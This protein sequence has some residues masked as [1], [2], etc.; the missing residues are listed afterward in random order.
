[1]PLDDAIVAYTA[2][3]NRDAALVM[4]LFAADGIEAYLFDNDS[5]AGDWIG[6]MVQAFDKPQVWISR[7]DAE[8]AAALVEELHEEFERLRAEREAAGTA[9]V[10][11]TVSARCEEC[12]R[13]SMFDSSLNG[14]VQ[15]CEYCRAYVDVGELDWG[16]D[17]DF[18]EE[19]AADDAEEHTDTDS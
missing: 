2:E 13:I 11:R 8:R 9:N 15:N 18:G 3:S 1:M 6:G 17:E 14:T 10:P 4:Q 5:L 12:G 7:K 19:D 16:E